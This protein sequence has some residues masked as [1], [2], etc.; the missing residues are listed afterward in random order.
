MGISILV[1][2]ITTKIIHLA[3]IQI[4]I[5]YQKYIAFAIS[6]IIALN[7][8]N[9]RLIHE[10]FH[11]RKPKK[12]RQHNGEKKKDKG[13][14]NDQQNIHIKLKDR[15][16]RNKKKTGGELRCF[17]RVSSS[18]STSGT[19]RVTFFFSPLCCLFFFGLRILITSLLSSNSSSS[20]D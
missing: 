18:C 13:T 17:G 9:Y 19:C 20:V 7:N 11:I 10:H 3:Y 5:T 16:T 6:F 12:N 4:L 8:N 15:G 1:I 2:I 14:N